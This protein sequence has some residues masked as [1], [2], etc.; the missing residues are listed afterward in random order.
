[1]E[2]IS[3]R[4]ER[5]EQQLRRT[6]LLAPE[7]PGGLAEEVRAIDRNIARLEAEIAKVEA[8]M[9]PA[10]VARSRAEFEE[11]DKSLDGLELDQEIEA[12][13]A[14]ITLLEAEEGEGGA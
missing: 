12:L 6:A 10:K 3:R 11:F 9:P 1:M 7:P 14:E 13:K 4:L 2:S 8:A 5:L